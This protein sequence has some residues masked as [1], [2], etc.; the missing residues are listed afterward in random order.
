M[1]IVSKCSGA[2]HWAVLPILTILE[3]YPGEWQIELGQHQLGMYRIP[4]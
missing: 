2:I 4:P 3:D 1:V